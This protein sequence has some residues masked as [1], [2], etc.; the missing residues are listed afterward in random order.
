[1]SMTNDLMQ[2]YILCNKKLWGAIFKPLRN[3]QTDIAQ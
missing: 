2:N 1:M 3:M